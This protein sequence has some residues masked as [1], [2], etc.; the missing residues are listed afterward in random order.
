MNNIGDVKITL[1]FGV[2]HP[3]T[4]KHEGVDLVYSDGVVKYPFY[5]GRVL[6][7]GYEPSGLGIYVVLRYVNEDR[8]SK[9]V[10]MAHFESTQVKVND[11]VFKGDPVGRQG[12]TGFVTGPHCHLELHAPID[13]VPLMGAYHER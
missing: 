12:S 9:V 6:Y 1:P 7:V 13:P 11:L 10:V 8:Q 2:S 4:G 5:R 3:V